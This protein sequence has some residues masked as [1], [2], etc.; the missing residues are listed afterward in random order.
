MPPD[1]D[2]VLPNGDGGAPNVPALGAEEPK[3]P[4]PG[5]INDDCS[6]ADVG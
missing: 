6:K 4:V 1:P 2:P 5:L 3:A